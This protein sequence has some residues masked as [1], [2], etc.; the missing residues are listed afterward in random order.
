MA[1]LDTQNKDQ[2]GQSDPIARL[3]KMSTTAGVAAQDYVAINS[4]AVTA[5]VLAVA[6]GLAFLGTYFLFIAP[7]AVGCGLLALRKIANSNGTEG[8]RPL[9]WFAIVLSLGLAGVILVK[10]IATLR[11]QAKERVQIRQVIAEF[12]KDIAA[13]EYEKAYELCD[14]EFQKKWTLAQ[15]R[16]TWVAYQDPDPLHGYGTFR[17]M[18]DNGIISFPAASAD[19]PIAWTQLIITGQTEAFRA[20][21]EL[22]KGPDGKWR[23]SILSKLFETPR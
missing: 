7:A 9:A 11:V 2:Q 15:F 14:G 21:S 5:A 1:E 18:E 22:I 19:R 23:F 3:H 13:G 16:A 20:S 12:G 4:L 6:T 10:T 17:R 8:G